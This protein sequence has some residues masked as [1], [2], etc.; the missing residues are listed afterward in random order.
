MA[1]Q[2]KY[3]TYQDFPFIEQIEKLKI[4]YLIKYDIYN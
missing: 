3:R 2:S 1:P 4:K